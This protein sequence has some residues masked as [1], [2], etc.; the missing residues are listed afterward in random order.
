MTERYE[1]LDGLRAIS[2]ICIIAMHIV[3]NADY[4]VHPILQTIMVS[5]THFVLLFIMIS[6]YGMCCGYYEKFKNKQIDLNQFFGK[7]YK[8]IGPF[9]I[10]LIILDILISRNMTH[11][12]EGLTEATLVFGLLPN[13]Q[14]EVIG[15]SWTLGVI[16]LFYMLFPYV[17][18]LCWNKKRAWVTFGISVVICFFCM[19]YY[20]SD[21]FVI[22]D[23]TP[24]HNILYCA[25]FLLGGVLVYLYRETIKKH[26]SRYRWIYLAVCIILSAAWYF[27]PNNYHGIDITNVSAFVVFSLWL[28]YAISIK[29]KLLSNG[30]TKFISGISLELYLSHMVAFR[31]VEKI[32]GLYVADHGWISIV[33]AWLLVMLI[34]ISLIVLWKYSAKKVAKMIRN[35]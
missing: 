35:V 12:V 28:M 25:P 6:G 32:H 20:F 26:I 18:Y 4:A 15:V 31:V 19:F 23:F 33:I 5:W 9:F 21:K 24:R 29:S 10:T 17:V 13:N 8:K 22:D 1:N 16:F 3:A 14:P 2:C 7:R 11:V 34:A 27:I 30:V